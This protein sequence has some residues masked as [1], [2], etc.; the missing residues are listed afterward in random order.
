M[1]LDLESLLKPFGFLSQVN[2]E[3]TNLPVT[4]ADGRVGVFMSAGSAM[5]QMDFGVKVAYDW[6]STAAISVPNTYAGAMCGLCGN[7]NLNPKDDLKMKGGKLAA[8]VEELGQS[9]RVAEIPGCVHGCKDKNH[10]PSCDI[11]QKEKFE[12]DV[13]CGRIRDPKGPFR[14]CHAVV[15]PSSYFEDCVY[16]VCLS[17]GR[18][19]SLCSSLQTYTA[20][21]QQKGVEVFEWRSKDFCSESHIPNCASSI[22]K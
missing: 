21:C 19:D 18:G 13:F 12:T 17:N 14:N 15:D 3:L 4:L 2:G 11:T 10:C 9:W 1:N 6:Q 7:Y 16:D 5:I 20:A 22:F 8:T